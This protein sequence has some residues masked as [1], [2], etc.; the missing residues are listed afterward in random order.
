MLTVPEVTLLL[1]ITAGIVKRN[2]FVP[3]AFQF[4]L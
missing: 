4:I 3:L 1:L 2:N